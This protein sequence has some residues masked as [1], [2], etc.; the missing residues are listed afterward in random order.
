MQNTPIT[1]NILHRITLAWAISECAL[2]GFMHAIKS[3]F[4]GLVVGGLSVVFIS[5]LAYHAEKPKAAILQAMVFVVGVKMAVSPHSPLG[6]YFAVAMQAVLGVLFFSLFKRFSIGAIFTGIFS[7]ALSSIQKVLI[8]TI[9]FG[10]SFW[11]TIDEFVLEVSDRFSFLNLG[12]DFSLTAWII[13]IYL[14]VYAIGGFCIGILAAR[15]PLIFTNRA[16]SFDDVIAH[17]EKGYSPKEQGIKEAKSWR[18]WPLVLAFIGIGILMQWLL[19][20][21]ESAFNQL[22]R[23]AIVLLSWILI[24]RP[25]IK[26]RLR[27][28]INK[29][30]HSLQSEIAQVQMSIP[31]LVAFAK[32]AWTQPA[33]SEQNKIL[34][35]ITIYVYYAIYKL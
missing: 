13:G 2:G 15:I 32:F 23:T 8:L 22:L 6:A 25:L 9:L 12:I 4:T 24:L 19:F 29:Q 35:F 27:K 11:A 28:S 5:L 21:S 33:K 1:P 14:T 26:W 30:A 31:T 10:A 16:K 18:I 20:S 34:Q 3:P 17:F 7:L